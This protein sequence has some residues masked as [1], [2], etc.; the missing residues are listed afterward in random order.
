MKGPWW[1]LFADDA[2]GNSGVLG[3]WELEVTYKAKK[4]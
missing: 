4:K 3:C 1:F 2:G